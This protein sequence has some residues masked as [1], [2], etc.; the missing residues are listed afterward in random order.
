MVFS[1][2]PSLKQQPSQRKRQKRGKIDSKNN[3]KYGGKLDRKLPLREQK[4]IGR[5]HV[6]KQNT[7]EI[8]SSHKNA[9]YAVKNTKKNKGQN[10][11]LNTGQK[12]P[13]RSPHP[14]FVLPFLQ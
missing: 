1:I 9:K 7:A 12:T 4:Q 3:A 6:K 10:T 2:R 11:A 5:K 14:D 8:H 13:R